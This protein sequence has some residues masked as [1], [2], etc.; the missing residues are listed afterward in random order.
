MSR[1]RYV[2]KTVEGEVAGQETPS[3][4]NSEH[5]PRQAN[6]SMQGIR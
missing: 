5:G 6:F 4:Q 3:L 2:A 1:T